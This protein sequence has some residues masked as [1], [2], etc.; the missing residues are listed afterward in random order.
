VRLSGYSSRDGLS[1]GV[2]QDLFVKAL[3]FQSGERPVVIV[4]SDLLYFD[5]ELLALVEEELA[6]APG[7]A[8]EQLIFTASH[9]HC[10]PVIRQRDTWIYGGRDEAYMV[11][12]RTALAA[13]VRDALRSLEPA[14]LTYHRATCDFN[15][16][17]RLKTPTGVEMLPNPDGVVDRDL[18]IL[19]VT[20]LDGTVRALLFSYTC[21]PTTMGGYLIGGDYPGSAQ[22]AIES[23]YPGATALFVQGCT[24]D[25]RP[26]NV[27]A[28]GRFKSG[29]LEVVE[30][31]GRRL[32][33]QVLAGMR[34]HG[35]SVDGPLHLADRVVDLPLMPHPS[36]A[37]LA[38]ALEDQSPFRRRWATD[39][40]G[41]CDRDEK[42]PTTWPVHLQ[43]VRIGDS[44]SLV[45]IAGEACVE[46]GLRIKELIGQGPRFVLGY[47][48]RVVGYIPSKSIHADGGYEVDGW[49]LYE[50]MPSHF[51]QSAEDLLVEAARAMLAR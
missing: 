18:D 41:K 13:V 30:R 4:T 7:L 47:T 28:N 10:G 27:E 21:H 17:R 9:T 19:V 32:A 35:T 40:L 14:R 1:E 48:N 25:V 33:E 31:F 8:P 5:D 26:N 6:R 37:Q 50:G 38:R 51:A 20:R 45:A 16:N 2:Y 34:G 43:T 29:P 39:M 22:R 36:R 42:L 15:I 23:A 24:G 44:L 49:Y 12:L 46:I 11:E 3:A